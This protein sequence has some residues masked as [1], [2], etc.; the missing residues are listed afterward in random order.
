MFLSKLFKK[1]FSKQIYCDLI[2]NFGNTYGDTFYTTYTLLEYD[3]LIEKYENF[4][5]K[6]DIRYAINIRDI[7]T[8][9]L[10]DRIL[11]TKHP[12]Y[13]I[14][15]QQYVLDTLMLEKQNRKNKEV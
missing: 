11:A 5:L 15:C 14:L 8:N 6:D 4:I 10:F 9:D 3:D 1:D 12:K 2:E 13:S 7:K